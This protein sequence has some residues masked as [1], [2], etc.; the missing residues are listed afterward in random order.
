MKKVPPCPNNVG[1]HACFGQVQADIVGTGGYLFHF[2]RY[3]T[4]GYQTASYRTKGYQTAVWYPQACL[5]FP[6]GVP[7][8]TNS[9]LPPLEN[10]ERCRKR[11]IERNGDAKPKTTEEVPV[12]ADATRPLL[13]HGR[14]RRRR[15]ETE[16]KV[17]IITTIFQPLSPTD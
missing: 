4:K 12:D 16:E 9:R 11:R 2:F 5:P 15:K 1:L 17:L 6:G 7:Q 14:E 10:A 13:R 8:G 3:R